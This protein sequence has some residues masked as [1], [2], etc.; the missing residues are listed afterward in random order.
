M[1]Q[2]SMKASGWLVSMKARGWLVSVKARGWPISASLSHPWL[3]GERGGTRSEEAS[4]ACFLSESLNPAA[5]S[6]L[7]VG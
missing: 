2:V 6:G 3:R 1:S 4:A 5:S 7:W